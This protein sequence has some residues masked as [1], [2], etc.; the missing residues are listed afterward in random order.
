[1]KNC[2]LPEWYWSRG[3]HDAKI[4]SVE[5]KQLSDW[6][7]YD[8]CLIFKINGHGA[9][10][11]QD[12]IEIRFFHFRFNKVDFDIFSLNGSWWLHDDISEK[13]GEYQLFLEFDDKNCERK[14]V[15]F[16]FKS[17][18]VTRRK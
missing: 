15:E 12:I 16:S 9:M 8:N 10:F 13:N 17:A 7:Q 3:L 1:M 4:V 11:D 5:I 18:E 14:T 2:N 6:N